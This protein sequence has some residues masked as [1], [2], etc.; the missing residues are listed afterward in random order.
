MGNIES[1]QLAE[2]L[3]SACWGINDTAGGQPQFLVALEGFLIHLEQVWGKLPDCV[4]NVIKRQFLPCFASST[5]PEA[6]VLQQIFGGAVDDMATYL[7]D[8]LNTLFGSTTG[9]NI[10]RFDIAKR[11]VWLVAF[12]RIRELHDGRSALADDLATKRAD[13]RVRDKCS[14]FAVAGKQLES[15][16]SGAGG[17]GALICG[18][19]LPFS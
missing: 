11:N 6:W 15:L 10:T 3:S 18:L 1:R 7:Y 17:S 13:D 5:D 4:T 19:S 9:F 14:N 8:E 12:T 2:T 16:L